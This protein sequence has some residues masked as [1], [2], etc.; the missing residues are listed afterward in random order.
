MPAS[1]IRRVRIFHGFSRLDFAEVFQVSERTVFRWE[2]DGVDP[3]SLALDPAA[4]SGPEWR[5]NY[6]KWLLER[7]EAAHVSDN[8]K[9]G[10]SHP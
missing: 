5:R 1:T 3:D 8:R 6:M 2:R 7:F 9:T 4:R 10:E